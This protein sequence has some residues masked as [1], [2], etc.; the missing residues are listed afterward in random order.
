MGTYHCMDTKTVDLLMMTI[1]VAG[2][3]LSCMIGF[4][5][6]NM[7]FGVPDDFNE[8]RDD[9]DFELYNMSGT[10][11][12]EEITWYVENDVILP[13]TKTPTA[14]PNATGDLKQGICCSQ[15]PK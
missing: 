10:H 9:P 1:M 6:M 2:A 7:V 13:L 12:S 11:W 8:A 5:V 14:S 3:I 15:F 4:T